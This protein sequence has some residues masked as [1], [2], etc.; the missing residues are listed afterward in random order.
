MH[1]GFPKFHAFPVLV[2][3]HYS[4]PSHPFDGLVCVENFLIF[5][6]H[7]LFLQKI[8]DLKIFLS[9]FIFP[10]GPVNWLRVVT[11]PFCIFWPNGSN[12]ASHLYCKTEIFYQLICSPAPH[13]AVDLKSYPYDSLCHWYLRYLWSRIRVGYTIQLSNKIFQFC[14]IGN[15]CLYAGHPYSLTDYVFCS[16]VN[17][18]ESRVSQRITGKIGSLAGS[19]PE[20]PTL[21]PPLLLFWESKRRFP[22]LRLFPSSFNRLFEPRGEWRKISPNTLD[23]NIQ[24]TKKL[25]MTVHFEVQ[26]LNPQESPFAGPSTFAD[27]LH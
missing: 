17:R 27:C 16:K 22:F 10:G 11:K 5:K 20:S 19:E 14:L 4:H 2:L 3:F 7:R 18:K 1:L 25:I 21:W 15:T 6:M 13:V 9:L 12:P 26:S 8:A 23:I 24:Q